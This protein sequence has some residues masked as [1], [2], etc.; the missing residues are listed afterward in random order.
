MF[1]EGDRERRVYDYLIENWGDI[2]TV[3]EKAL[4]LDSL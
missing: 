2:M 3:D 1:A 4:L